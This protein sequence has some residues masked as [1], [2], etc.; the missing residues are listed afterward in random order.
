MRTPTLSSRSGSIPM[1]NWSIMMLGVLGG[2]LVSQAAWATKDSYTEEAS[3]R[4]ICR[5]NVLKTNGKAHLIEYVFQNAKQSKNTTPF[6]IQ[7]KPLQEDYCKGSTVLYGYAA[8]DILATEASQLTVWGADGRKR[9]EGSYG[10]NGDKVGTWT[11]YFNNGAIN[12]KTV[13]PKKINGPVQYEHW[14]EDGSMVSRQFSDGWSSFIPNE[15][16]K[17]K[18]QTTHE[19]CDIKILKQ[20]KDMYLIEFVFANKTKNTTPFWT[21]DT[22]LKRDYCRDARFVTEENY[23][24]YVRRASKFVIWN[25]QGKKVADGNYSRFGRR[26]GMWSTYYPNGQMKSTQDT[27]G[28]GIYQSWYANGQLRSDV[29]NGP[30]GGVAKYW[31]QGNRSSQP[32]KTVKTFVNLNREATEKIFNKQGKLIAYKKWDLTQGSRLVVNEMY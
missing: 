18:S 27:N 29:D 31:N 6:W 2:V 5:V 25:Q 8:Q 7:G 17:A 11:S 26:E 24:R 15:S 9:V 3:N 4:P 21:V 23:D 32:D 1:G 13:Y 22:P 10:L 20:E 19:I 16:K 12:T 28:N 30:M 14:R